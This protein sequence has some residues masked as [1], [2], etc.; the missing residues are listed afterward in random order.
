MTL[1]S[2]HALKMICSEAPIRTPKPSLSNLYM[3][4]TVLA[5]VFVGVESKLRSIFRLRGGK[6]RIT[7][8]FRNEWIIISNALCSR[9]QQSNSILL[10]GG[11]VVA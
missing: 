6:Y 4:L 11:H 2:T 7:I 5:Y 10:R 1:K 3:A 9:D 8:T